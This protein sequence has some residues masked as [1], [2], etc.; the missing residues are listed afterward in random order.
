MKHGKNKIKV[1]T[2]KSFGPEDD[3]KKAIILLEDLNSY[4]KCTT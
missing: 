4:K 1:N 3:I 2:S